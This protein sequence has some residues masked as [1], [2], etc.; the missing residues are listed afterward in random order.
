MNDTSLM[1]IEKYKN[2]KLKEYGLDKDSMLEFQSKI[3]KVE[4]EESDKLGKELYNL[5]NSKSIT[6]DAETEKKATELIISGANLEYKEEKKGNFSLLKSIINGKE[7]L[8]ILLI[9]A[10]ANINQTNDFETTPLISASRHGYD[11]LVELLLILGASVNAQSIDLETAIF[12]AKRHDQKK[13]YDLLVNSGAYINARNISNLSIYDISFAK[14]VK[15]GN[16]SIYLPNLID[17]SVL[18]MSQHKSS[19]DCENLIEEAEN[20][21]NKI[22]TLK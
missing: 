6:D 18:K 11:N 2:N 16:N 5:I 12:S 3:K 15:A 21:L 1:D 13:C 19:E 9:K 14:E 7:N 17:K 10:G 4:Q 22:K 8:A 20:A